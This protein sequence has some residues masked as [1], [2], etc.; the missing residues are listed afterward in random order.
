LPWSIKLEEEIPEDVK[1]AL[2]EKGHLIQWPVGGYERGIFGRGHVIT[3]GAWF[4]QTGDVY[5]GTNVWWGAADPRC[6]GYP[7]GY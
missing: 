4:V 7:L 6:D 2:E 1:I 5:T 3:R